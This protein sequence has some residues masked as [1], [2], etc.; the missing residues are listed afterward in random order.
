MLTFENRL[1][2]NAKRTHPLQGVYLLLILAGIFDIL[3]SSDIRNPLRGVFNVIEYAHILSHLR[4]IG[5]F[6]ESQTFT[7]GMFL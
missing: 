2:V 5:V 4:V 1:W 7:L 3:Y 6:Y